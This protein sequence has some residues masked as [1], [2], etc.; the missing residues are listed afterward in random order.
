MPRIDAIRRHDL[1]DAQWE[2]LEPLLPVRSGLGRPLAF[3]LRDLIDGVRHRARTGAPWRDVPPVYGPWWRVYALFRSWQILGVWQ[4]IESGML[5]E[6]DRR[7]MLDWGAFSV[8]STSVR[9]HVHAAG[10]RRD[11][12]SRVAGEPDDHALGRSRGGWGTKVHLGW[13]S[14]RGVVSTLLTA[15]QAGDPQHLIPVLNQVRVARPGRVGRPRQRPDRVLADAAYSSRG[16]RSWLARRGIR[17]TIPIKADQAR[18]RAA[19]GSRGGRPPK[20]DEVSYHDR[21]AVECGINGMKQYRGFATRC[22][23]LAVRYQATV[24]V[25]NISRWLKQLS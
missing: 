4:R 18:H 14:G 2:L 13:E 5:D 23:K 24:R 11:S 6:A 25:V 21:H 7:G 12:V 15:G 20:F 3:G 19:R 17:A 8:D 1:T 9:A 22:D 16:N 10:A